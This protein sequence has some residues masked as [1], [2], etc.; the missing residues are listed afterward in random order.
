[1]N[2]RKTF[3]FL[4]F[5]PRRFFPVT[6]FNRARERATSE[7]ESD[8]H[9]ETWVARRESKQ[10]EKSKTMKSFNFHM[11]ISLRAAE[12]GQKSQNTK[13]S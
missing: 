3:D 8:I 5:L 6:Q 10:E 12:P 9:V 1:M 13:L 11:I 2:G 4:L 7:I